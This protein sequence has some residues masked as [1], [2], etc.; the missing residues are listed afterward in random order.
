M[1]EAIRNEYLAIC[2]TLKT[3]EDLNYFE[4]AE[5]IHAKLPELDLDYITVTVKAWMIPSVGTRYY[6]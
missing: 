2:D 1:Q 4:M 5:A 6:G 3:S